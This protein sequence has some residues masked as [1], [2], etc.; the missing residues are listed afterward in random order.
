MYFSHVCAGK[1]LGTFI[2]YVYCVPHGPGS[3]QCPGSS[4]ANP[5]AE[6]RSLSP[7]RRFRLVHFYPSLTSATEELKEMDW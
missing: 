1:V 2:L 6:I 5:N 7:E 3:T 4:R